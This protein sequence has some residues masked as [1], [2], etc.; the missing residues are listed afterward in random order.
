MMK[1][2]L[3]LIGFLLIMLVGCSVTDMTLRGESE[4]WS[5]T[6]EYKAS[7]EYKEYTGSI[8]YNG[9]E[10]IE[11]VSYQINAPSF[12]GMNAS[13]NLEAYEENQKVFPLGRSGGTGTNYDK[14][15]IK[16]ALEDVTITVQWVTAEG[17]Y[18]EIIEF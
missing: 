13:G 14:Q 1:S 3:V 7:E 12:L 5:S 8:K 4:S 11:T 18:E 17:E 10:E 2:H 9:E 15:M 16:D 6:I